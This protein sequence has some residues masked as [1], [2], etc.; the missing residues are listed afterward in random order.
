MS[1]KKSKNL[2]EPYPYI[3]FVPSCLKDEGSCKNDNYVL[4][5]FFNFLKND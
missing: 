2:E 5:L 4:S 3:L 1:K